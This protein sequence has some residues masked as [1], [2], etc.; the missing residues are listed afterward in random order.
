MTETVNY[1]IELTNYEKAV[2]VA[3]RLQDELTKVK[4]TAL[5]LSELMNHLHDPI[6]D[7]HSFRIVPER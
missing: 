3:V 2:E 7:G 5:E 1:K 4:E 6:A